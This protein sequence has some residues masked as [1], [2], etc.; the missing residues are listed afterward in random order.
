M[1]GEADRRRHKH[2]IVEK[3]KWRYASRLVKMNSIK[4]GAM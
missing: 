1:D 4:K 2:S 3:K